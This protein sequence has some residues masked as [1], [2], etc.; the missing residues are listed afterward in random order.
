MPEGDLATLR[1]QVCHLAADWLAAAGDHLWTS[2]HLMKE[3]ETEA[4]GVVVQIIG[5]LGQ[6]AADAFDRG[7]HYAGSA[8]A[9]QIV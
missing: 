4:V 3:D 5:Q 8:L 6:E 2:G 9:R 7:R 1:S